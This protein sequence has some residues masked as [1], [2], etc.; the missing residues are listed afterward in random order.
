[1]SGMRPLGKLISLEEALRI[2]DRVSK[3]IERRERVPIWSALDRVLAEDIKAG[4]SVPSFA[5]SAMDGFAVR[6]IDVK[7]ASK[8]EPVVL[9]IIDKV[10]AGDVATRSVSSGQCVEIATGGMLP[11]GADSVIIVEATRRESAKGVAVTAPVRRG[12]HVISPGD[13]IKEGAIVAHKGE[14]LTPAKIGSIAAVGVDGVIAYERPNVIVMPTGDEVIR[15]GEKLKPGQVY[16]VNTFTLK[17]AV[18]SFGGAVDVRLIVDDSK[19]SLLEAIESES[20]ADIIIFSGGSSVGERDLI[21]DAVS[22]LGNVLFH[23]VAIR[24][25]K[26]TLLGKVGKSIVL[27]MPGH[28]TSCLS[29][30]YIF[31]EPMI[32]KIG[33]IPKR[34][35]RVRKSRIASDVRLS[36][37]RTTIITVRVNGECAVPAFKESSAITSMANAD[38]YLVIPPGKEMLRKGSMVDVIEF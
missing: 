22:E 37:G 14:P 8:K 4:I 34:H 12:E 1:M 33:R 21:V 20:G 13:D 23:G 2:C 36:P 3:P 35:K 7:R 30:A 29:N 27:G 32:T 38:G 26:P 17:S 11:K 31:L 19:K 5:R 16:D 25:G 15:P 10:F 28:P 9:R 6:A 24:P 18:E